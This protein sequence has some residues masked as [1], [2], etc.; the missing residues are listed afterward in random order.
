MKIFALLLLL[1]FCFCGC[2]TKMAVEGAKHNPADALLVPVTVPIDV[3]GY[4]IE[5]DMGK[6]LG[7]IQ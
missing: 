4:P 5:Q 1:S 7:Q 2:A 6:K 3:L